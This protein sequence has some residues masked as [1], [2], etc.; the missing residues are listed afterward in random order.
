MTLLLADTEESLSI[1]YAAEWESMD[2]YVTRRVYTDKCERMS[3]TSRVR[4]EE[5]A[6]EAKQNHVVTYLAKLFHAEIKDIQLCDQSGVEAFPIS[7]EAE[8]KLMAHRG[9]VR[10]NTGV[11]A[12]S[13]E[14]LGPR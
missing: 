1:S 13:G 6:Q 11:R 10:E 14:F 4:L 7:V 9:I 8:K 3:M 5:A 2:F 12:V